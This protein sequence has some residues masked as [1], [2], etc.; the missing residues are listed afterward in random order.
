MKTRTL[1]AAG[2]EVGAVG[3]GCMGMSW[4][5]TE[6]LRDDEASVAVLR[7]ALDL[8]VTFIDTADVYGDGHNETLVG[9][10]L[11]GRRDE[12]FLATKAGLVVDDLATKSMHRN[13]SP[14]HLRRAVEA[15][16]R[17]LDVERI[18]L[19]YLHRIDPEVPLEDTWGAMAELVAAGK[20]AH[21]G[22]SEVSAG[23]AATA[24]TIH[25]VAAVQSE[26]SLWWR[27]AAGQAQFGGETGQGSGGGGLEGE[28]GDVVGWC[29]AND[30]VF[31]P[32]APL[33][34]GYLTGVISA[35]TSF[36]DGD[37]RSVN[38][39]FAPA[40]RA[41]NQRILDVVAAVAKRRDIL[42]AQVALA[43][44]LAQGEHI[45][46]IPG[47]KQL[48]YLEQNAASADVELTAEDLEQLRTIPEAVGSRY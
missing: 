3:L 4:A 42:P 29:A 25:P 1:A 20:V 32:F 23:Q 15:S 12:A 48:R 47:T 43:W 10:A 34:R 19:Y 40:A 18:D 17:R 26:F 38:P 39:R 21:L 46:P 31:T 11:A 5:Y 14:G 44:V 27:S 37:M 8:G 9:R 22:L 45:V 16:L 7:A 35:R 30:A 36:E 13:G 6:S 41:A 2:R 24:H 33:G 28:S